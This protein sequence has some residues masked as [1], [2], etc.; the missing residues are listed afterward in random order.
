MCT[1][2]K[3]GLFSLFELLDV[4]LLFLSVCEGSGLPV[5]SIFA[6][7]NVCDHA[8]FCS[9]ATS[10]AASFFLDYNCIKSGNIEKYT[11]SKSVSI[12]FTHSE[13]ASP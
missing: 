3:S 12:F 11:W 4:L 2:V 8:C 13:M 5:L 9:P 10:L 1:S 7:Y 6:L